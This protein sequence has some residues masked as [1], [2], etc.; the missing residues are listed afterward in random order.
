MG[1]VA[2]CSHVRDGGSAC[3]QRRS[4]SHGKPLHEKAVGSLA[5]VPTPFLRNQADT[6]FVDADENSL[7]LGCVYALQEIAPPPQRHRLA[8]PQK[9]QKQSPSRKNRGRFPELVNIGRLLCGPKI[10]FEKRPTFFAHS[11][12]PGCKMKP[13]GCFFVRLSARGPCRASPSCPSVRWPG[14][15]AT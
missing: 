6:C 9:T 12:G 5:Y 7:S 13:A 14:I 10:A 3:S 1:F 2:D 11:T 4:A 8:R 15:S